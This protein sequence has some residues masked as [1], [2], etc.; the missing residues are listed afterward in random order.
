M[1]VLCL[2]NSLDAG[3]AERR[4]V[5]IAPLLQA[6]GFDIVVSV[7]SSGGAFDDEL[8]SSGVAMVDVQGPGGR[9]GN[10]RRLRALIRDIRPDLLHTTLFESDLLGRAVAVFERVPVVSS[11]VNESYGSDQAAE[12]AM[13]RT[14]LRKARLVDGATA[15]VVRRSHA[16]SGTVADVAARELRLRRDR[17]DVV[18]PGRD[19]IRL[20]RRTSDRRRTARGAL[21]LEDADHLLLAVARHEYQKGL[22]VLLRGSLPSAG[23]CRVHVFSSPATRVARP[24]S[25]TTYAAGTT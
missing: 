16:V 14:T 6:R 4:L 8:A 13:L 21:G 24:P 11:L 25:S 3:G 18:S 7:L 19:P 1:R 2:I 23:H 9:A 22:D 15:R 5:E 12:P 17:I 10:L 20:G